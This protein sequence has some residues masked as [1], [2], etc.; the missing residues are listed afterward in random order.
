MINLLQ[1]VDSIEDGVISLLQDNSY[2][3]WADPC[4]NPD[5]PTL[6]HHVIQL[7]AKLAYLSTPI[8]TMMI[9]N[10]TISRL[11]DFFLT[12]SWSKEVFSDLMDFFSNV[13]SDSPEARM[14]TYG[15]GVF[16]SLCNILIQTN[17]TETLLLTTMCINSFFPDAQLVV[18]DHIADTILVPVR[19]LI[20]RFID[21]Q[22]TDK[23]AGDILYYAL[24][25]LSKFCTTREN[26]N[27]TV[28]VGLA[29]QILSV[30]NV[31][32]RPDTLD[33]I[34]E[35]ISVILSANDTA[36][37]ETIQSDINLEFLIKKGGRVICDILVSLFI[38]DETFV[39]PALSLDAIHMALPILEYGQY[40]EKLSAA[41]L[42]ANGTVVEEYFMDEHLIRELLDFW[43]DEQKQPI[44]AALDKLMDVAKQN[45]NVD[46]KY[47][48]LIGLFRD[49][50]FIAEDSNGSA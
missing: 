22:T 27:N 44:V 49:Y 5:H 39:V 41:S 12:T 18:E 26:I 28:K 4:I 23:T 40:E 8:V 3:K 38:A 43:K 1:G 31:I 25:A 34:L 9:E 36:I 24:S 20:E 2:F 37:F 10:Q 16:D 50:G 45:I 29:N 21:Q 32:A 30:A 11:S 7:N 35:T 33:I 17:E 6:V 47:D 42:R 48:R 13:C 15:K 19:S 14:L 46:T